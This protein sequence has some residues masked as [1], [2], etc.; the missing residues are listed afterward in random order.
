MMVSDT[1]FFPLGILND[2]EWLPCSKSEYCFNKTD[3][4]RKNVSNWRA[5]INNNSRIAL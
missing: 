5:L 3:D 1:Y 4:N 2:E